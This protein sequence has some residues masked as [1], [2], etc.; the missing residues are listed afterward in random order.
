MILSSGGFFPYLKRYFNLVLRY[1]KHQGNLNGKK[2][3]KKKYIFVVNRP[4]KNC[5]EVQTFIHANC[6]KRTSGEILHSNPELMMQDF[7]LLIRC[8]TCW[9]RRDFI[10]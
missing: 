7:H 3:K 1:T 6:H 10:L 2:K 9:M 5:L 4:A 8:Y